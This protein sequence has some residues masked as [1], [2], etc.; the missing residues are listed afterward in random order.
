MLNFRKTMFAVLSAAMLIQGCASTSGAHKSSVQKQA[1]AKV[2]S[3]HKDDVNNQSFA[4]WDDS[5][6]LDDSV[7]RRG[8]KAR[9]AQLDY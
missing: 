5:K 1:E 6:E 2:K 4:L 9:G 7:L 8:A 3:H